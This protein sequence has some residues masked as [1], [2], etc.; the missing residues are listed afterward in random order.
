MPTELHALRTLGSKTD[1]VGRTGR[2]C[3][4]DMCI[5]DRATVSAACPG[6]FFFHI[7]KLTR[8]SLMS[9]KMLLLS[10][11]SYL[12]FS[13]LLTISAAYVVNPPHNV[14]SSR[15]VNL[16][17]KYVD[18]DTISFN[19]YHI[20]DCGSPQAMPPKLNALLGFLFQMKPHLQGVINDARQGT[21]SQHGY[22]AFFK[23]SINM[24]RVIAAYQ[25]LVDAAPVI[26][27]EERAKII[28]THT[29]Q[30]KF[31][32]IN[33]N[34]PNTED[35]MELC[36][37]GLRH[38]FPSHNPVIHRPGT[39]LILV[40]PSFFQ[41]TQYPPPER[42]CPTL[43]ANGKFRRGDYKLLGGAFAYTVYTL[44]F[45]YN[46]EM[47]ETYEDFNSLWDMQYAVELNSRQSVL[48]PESYGFYAGGEFALSV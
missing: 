2:Q 29:P 9:V 12:F 42:I 30:P 34:D 47:Y 39:E 28:G 44:V 21:R 18:A 27:H 45:M 16:D 22:T 14:L 3:A 15:Q 31:Q 10:S 7:I 17:I 35:V 32:C 26:V 20:Y 8:Q 1:L 4:C 11:W 37:R 24:R 13:A 40:C 46:R 6:G 43:G 19:G 48:N 5:A 25:R 38:G 41:L 33:E 23:S 36:D